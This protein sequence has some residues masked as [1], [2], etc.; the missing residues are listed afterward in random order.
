MRCSIMPQLNV[1]AD[2]FLPL[3]NPGTL[4][5]SSPKSHLDWTGNR[6]ANE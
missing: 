3:L 1:P 5:T 2:G 4:A 6:R